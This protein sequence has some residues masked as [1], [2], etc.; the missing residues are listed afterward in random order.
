MGLA[1]SSRN[2]W[3]WLITYQQ[4]QATC[5]LRAN[6]THTD[7]FILSMPPIHHLHANERQWA[8]PIISIFM[9]VL[10]QA[11]S[12]HTRS[13]S[14]NENRKEKKTNNEIYCTCEIIDCLDFNGKSALW[15]HHTW[16]FFQFPE[17]S[18]SWIASNRFRIAQAT[19]VGWWVA[20]KPLLPNVW[21]WVLMSAKCS[22]APSHHHW[23]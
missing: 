17:Q 12:T 22:L 16:R 2:G 8:H 19:I 21:F 1:V 7:I 10:W 13:R 3:L 18:L 5:V 9:F 15:S 11:L 20:S 23:P 6:S 14:A 4:E